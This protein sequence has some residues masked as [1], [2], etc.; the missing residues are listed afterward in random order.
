MIES[1][2]KQKQQ[3]VRSCCK[4]DVFRRRCKIAMLIFNIVSFKRDDV[5]KFLNKRDLD[6]ATVTPRYISAH[7]ESKTGQFHAFFLKNPKKTLKC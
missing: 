1:Y 2:R 6:Q 4:K 5:R 7:Y 3:K